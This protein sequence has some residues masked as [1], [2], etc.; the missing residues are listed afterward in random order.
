MNIKTS[1]KRFWEQ[2]TAD[3]YYT[4]ANQDCATT[5]PVAQTGETN[6]WSTY[7]VDDDK[8]NP[9]CTPHTDLT[10]FKCS[11]IKC[12]Y[13]RKMDTEAADGRD[14]QFYPENNNG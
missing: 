5:A 1:D 6:D 3:K 11:K 10:T 14:F 7:E 4:C 9:F 8:N 13:R 12:K 2:K